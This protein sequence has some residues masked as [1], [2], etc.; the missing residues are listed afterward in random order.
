MV[1]RLHPGSLITAI[2]HPCDTFANYGTWEIN[3]RSK[4]GL[5]PSPPSSSPS[6]TVNGQP[7]ISASAPPLF[8]R[9]AYLLLTGCALMHQR[10][11]AMGLPPQFQ[12]HDNPAA[13]APLVLT[14]VSSHSDINNNSTNIFE[15]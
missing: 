13:A 9:L 6:S 10:C 3:N 14:R 1:G 2:C 15:K 4:C 7:N 8:G 12:A 5:S 11:K